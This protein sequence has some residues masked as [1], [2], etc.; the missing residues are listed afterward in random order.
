MK[1]NN[2]EFVLLQTNDVT[3]KYIKHSHNDLYAKYNKYLDEALT[4]ESKISDDDLYNKIL[5]LRDE[6]LEIE[7]EE[8]NKLN[9]YKLLYMI[10][11][12]VQSYLNDY[13]FRDY[14]HYENYF[15]FDSIEFF[16][17]KV[18][19]MLASN[20]LRTGDHKITNIIRKGKSL[21]KL[22]DKLYSD[23]NSFEEFVFEID[24][25]DEI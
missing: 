19:S 14:L 17:S 13:H 10:N 9:Q 3:L 23:F 8:C 15:I 20:F 16:T 18:N 2:C 4:Y 21:L 12:R 25:N 22:L 1:L 11:N 7:I 24:E 6:I 5:C